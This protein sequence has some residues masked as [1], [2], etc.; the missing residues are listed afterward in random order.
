MTF[1]KPGRI[2]IPMQTILS[3]FFWGFMLLSS[4]LLFPV[5]LTL[6]V[7]TAPFDRQLRILHQFTSLWGSLYTWC[8]PLWSVRIHGMELIDRSEAYVM[9]CNHQSLLDI[10]ILFRLRVHYKWVSKGENFRIP[11][12]GWNMTLN[13]YI[14]I[15]RGKLR[16]NLQMMRDAEQAL[17][18]GNSIMIFPEGTRSADGAVGPFKDGA[19]ELA[20]RTGR[21]I[22]PLVVDGTARAL[23]KRGFV[24]RGTSAMTIR[25]LP[26]ISVAEI[27]RD[28][29]AATRERVRQMITEAKGPA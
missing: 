8:N 15:E 14:R 4:I 26:P 11:F 29:A 1:L 20:Q 19:F 18:E 7:F 2:L 28:G 24:L 17:R 27:A 25:I 3:L 16:G 10:L 13:R 23:P 22:L 12:I 21:P 9:V 6:R 5:A